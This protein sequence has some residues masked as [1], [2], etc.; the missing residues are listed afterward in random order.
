MCRI[1]NVKNVN[2]VYVI[3]IV[4]HYGCKDYGRNYVTFSSNILVPVF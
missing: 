2:V 3:A 4:N 1:F